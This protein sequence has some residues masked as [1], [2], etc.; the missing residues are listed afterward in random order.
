[1]KFNLIKTDNTES[2]VVINSLTDAQK[3]VGGFIQLI[4]LV[5][6]NYDSIDMYIH[7][8]GKL[9]KLPINEKATKLFQEYTC[10]NDF[11]VGDVIIAKKNNKI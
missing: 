7:E 5:N 10:E 4:Q 9:L 8:E 1:M 2:E 11:I 6:K 3:F